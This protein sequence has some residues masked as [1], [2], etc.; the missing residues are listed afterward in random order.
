LIDGV[1]VKRLEVKADERGRLVELFRSD[2]PD[3]RGFGQVHLTTVR[4][5]VVKAWR[6]HKTR[7][8]VLAAVA[9]MVRLGLYDGRS[10]GKTEGEL[11]QFFLGVHSP[12][13]V[14]IPPGVW[15]GLKG[16]GAEEALVVVCTDAPYDPRDPDEEHWDPV[17]NEIPFDW[18]RR[19]R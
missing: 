19:D 14:T 3:F 13:R 7:T 15:F 5:G 4:A 16:V 11:R 1:V 6:R 9:G 2:D 18:D 12:L 10:G 8:D 17:I